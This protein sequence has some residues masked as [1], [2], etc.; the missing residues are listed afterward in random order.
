MPNVLGFSKSQKCTTMDNIYKNADL[1]KVE[2]SSYTIRMAINQRAGHPH[3]VSGQ[4]MLIHTRH[5]MPMLRCGFEKSL[6]EWHGRG[7]AR[8]RHG[9]CESNMAA[10]CKSNGKDTI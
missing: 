9:T 2:E 8:V 3:A 6:S 1:P 10:L 7:M 5:A 4:P